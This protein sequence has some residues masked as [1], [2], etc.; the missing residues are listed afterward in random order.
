MFEWVLLYLHRTGQSEGREI[1]MI[2]GVKDLLTN[3]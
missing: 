3:I 1:R 2:M